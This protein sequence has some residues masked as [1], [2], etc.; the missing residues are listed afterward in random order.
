VKYLTDEANAISELA[1]IDVRIAR[2]AAQLVSSP[3]DGV[4]LKRLPGQEGDLI[5]AGTELSVLIPST[6]SRALELWVKGNDMPL[7]QQGQ[8]VRVHF[9]GWPA[10]Q[11]SGWPSVAIGTFPGK[12]QWVDPTSNDK[13]LFRVMVTPIKDVEWPDARYLRQGV[14]AVAWVNIKTVSLGYEIWRQ[15]NAFPIVPEMQSEQ[16]EGNKK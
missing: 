5:K 13:G 1:K 4:I 3:T 12:V 8:D 2:Q 11:F 9:E 7:I 15:F 10:I 16:K 14:R 6:E